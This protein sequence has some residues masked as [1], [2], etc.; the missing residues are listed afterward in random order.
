[1]SETWL[2]FSVI[3]SAGNET[4]IVN[5]RNQLPPAACCSHM[6]ANMADDSVTAFIVGHSAAALP[7]PHET[8][9]FPPRRPFVPSAPL[10]AARL[11]AAGDVYSRSGLCPANGPLVRIARITFFPNAKNAFK[12]A[13]EESSVD[14]NDSAC[15]VR[16]LSAVTALQ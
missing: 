13:W 1:M 4:P 10:A 15:G 2:F 5:A 3:K 12:S 16:R 7:S 9:W 11:Q 6:L 8:P 14:L